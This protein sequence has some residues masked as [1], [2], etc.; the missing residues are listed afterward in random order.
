[1]K[2]NLFATSLIAT[3]SSAFANDPHCDEQQPT[4]CGIIPEGVFI[5]FKLIDG[6]KVQFD[7]VTKDNTW[8]GLVLGSNLMSYPSDMVVFSAKGADD[9]E[10]IDLTSDPYGSPYGNTAPLTDVQ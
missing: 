6:D 2:Y 4:D 9:S 8:V 10:C 3:I 5:D 1:M 7:V